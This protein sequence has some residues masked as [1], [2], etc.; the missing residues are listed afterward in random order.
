M[1]KPLAS[2][3]HIYPFLSALKTGRGYRARGGILLTAHK[4]F[5][6]NFIWITLPVQMQISFRFPT[7]I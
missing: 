1:N 3:S 6:H 5:H 2:A 7:N 4:D